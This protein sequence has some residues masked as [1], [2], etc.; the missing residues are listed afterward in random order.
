MFCPFNDRSFF[1][2]LVAIIGRKLAWS[3][4]SYCCRRTISIEFQGVTLSLWQFGTLSNRS[5]EI[6]RHLQWISTHENRCKRIDLLEKFRSFSTILQKSLSR[7]FYDQLF[8]SSSTTSLEYLHTKTISIRWTSIL[9]IFH[10]DFVLSFDQFIN[11][12][13]DFLSE[14][15]RRTNS[16]GTISERYVSNG[17]SLDRS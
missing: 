14:N 1:S 10:L 13:R 5:G 12:R 8:T 6:R 7:S 16:Y 9:Q 3:I 11:D 2:C 15:H 17:G 4:P